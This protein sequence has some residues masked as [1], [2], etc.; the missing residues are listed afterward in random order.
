MLQ[1][2]YVLYSL[3][4]IVKI[5]KSLFAAGSLRAQSVLCRASSRTIEE[6]G[7]KSYDLECYKVYRR[8]KA[9]KEYFPKRREMPLLYF[10]L[11]LNENSQMT[12]QSL[13]GV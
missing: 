5:A 1:V 7:W 4:V 8:Y 13:D 3:E 12:Q 10:F 11:F 6:Y 9:G 2:G